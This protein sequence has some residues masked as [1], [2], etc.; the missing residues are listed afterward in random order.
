MAMTVALGVD[1][2]EA[3]GYVV[4]NEEGAI[5]KI[6]RLRKTRGKYQS[7]VIK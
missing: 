5:K 6:D 3:L 2:Q 4:F 1:T 7:N